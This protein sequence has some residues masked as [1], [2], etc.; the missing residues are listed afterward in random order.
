VRAR[1]KADSVGGMNLRFKTNLIEHTKAVGAWARRQGAKAFVDAGD[2]GLTVVVGEREF[3]LQPQFVGKRE[4]GQLMYFDQAD[5]FAVGFVGWLPYK[6][7]AWDISLSKLAF[8]AAAQAVGLR[9][10][11]HWLRA[12]EVSGPCLVK[13]ERGA[14]G[15]GMRGPY[16]P[17]QARAL[18]ALQ[19]GEYCEAFVWGHI[20]RAWYWSGA[21]AVLEVFEMPSVQGDG[22]SRY[23]E[24]LQRQA[25]ELPADFEVLARLQG[26]AADDV[27][28][29]GRR[30]VCDYRYVSPLN[31]T[32]YANSNL[33][34]RGR[35]ASSSDLVR[36]FE[37]AGK[38][39]WP[40]IPA[41]DTLAGRQ[42]GFVLDAIV[43]VE[44]R[45]WF[46][47]V[48]SNAQGHPDVYAPMLDALCA[49]ALAG[50]LRSAA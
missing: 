29:A 31:P 6:P 8:K 11:A 48:N 49:P 10:P 25:V 12:S 4:S 5:Q 24:L 41:P 1:G 33:L 14:F 38:R 50:A 17:Q 3:K 47:E 26:V 19:D 30:V 20:A 13:R 22:K 27:L 37:D 45:P 15:Y 21:L 40:R 7:L 2:F 43:D 35:G 32:V 44:G 46:L 34:R 42:A 28:P 23:R 18:D 9:T 16:L 39:L 36:A